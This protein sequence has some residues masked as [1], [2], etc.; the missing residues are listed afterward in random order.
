MFCKPYEKGRIMSRLFRA[1]Q[2]TIGYLVVAL[3]LIGSGIFMFTDSWNT[4]ED[5]ETTATISTAAPTEGADASTSSSSDDRCSK[6]AS[7]C[8]GSKCCSPAI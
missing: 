5:V 6:G 3:L 8:C 2:N 1:H 4:S 7:L